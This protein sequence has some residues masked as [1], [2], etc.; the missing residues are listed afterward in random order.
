MGKEDGRPVGLEVGSFVGAVN[1]GKEDGRV[2]CPDG[3]IVGRHIG[4]ID[5]G[6]EDG[7]LLGL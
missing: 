6:K 1:V 3:L 5:V 7:R 4:A 2:G